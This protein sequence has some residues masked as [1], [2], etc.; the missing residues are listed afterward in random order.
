VQQL[1]ADDVDIGIAGHPKEG[2]GSSGRIP[3]LSDRVGLGVHGDPR[4][5][6]ETLDAMQFFA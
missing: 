4:P 2:T 6:P 3:D 5:T 1:A